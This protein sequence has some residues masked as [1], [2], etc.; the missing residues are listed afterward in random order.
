MLYTANLE[1][2]HLQSNIRKK[3]NI[4]K[5]FRKTTLDSRQIVNKASLILEVLKSLLSLI[6]DLTF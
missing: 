3:D 2:Q 6:E 1:N 4:L 5:A